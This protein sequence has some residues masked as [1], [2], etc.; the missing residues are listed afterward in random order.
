M[1][2]PRSRH[3]APHQLPSGRHGLSATYVVENQRRRILD[4]VVQ[5]VAGMGYGAMTVEHVV[6][7]AGVSRRTF[8][9]N[10]PNKEVA[11]LTA[12]DRIV[13]HLFA[14]VDIAYAEP[15]GWSVRVRRGLE[16]F[17]DFLGREPTVA[18]VCFV[19]ILAA[20]PQALSRRTGAM[21]RFRAFF[22]SDEIAGQPDWQVPPCATDAAI[23][24][25]YEMVYGRVLDGDAASLPE[26]LPDML[27][28]LL[29]PFAGP[30]IAGAQY[31]SALRDRRLEIAAE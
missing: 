11:F 9:A 10:F 3:R 16:V 22:A 26:L 8:Y 15:G 14:A 31:D 2:A 30:Q 7:V 1:S 28:T 24:G 19:D 4:A 18:H 6:S 5:V 29:L 27:H 13:D 20:G 23:G 25:A 21:E 17:L 12:Y